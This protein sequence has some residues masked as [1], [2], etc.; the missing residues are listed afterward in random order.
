MSALWLQIVL[1]ALA[2]SLLP[3]WVHGV[4]LSVFSVLSWFLGLANCHASFCS[5]LW[6]GLSQIT[7]WPITEADLSPGELWISQLPA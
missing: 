1:G 4:E 5:H 7:I 3:P 6:H 2:V